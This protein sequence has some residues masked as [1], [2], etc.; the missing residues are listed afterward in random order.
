MDHEGGC[1]CGN[2]TLTLRL[3]KP[4]ADNPTRSCACSFCRGHATRTTSD[5]RGQADIRARDRTAVE[6]YRF[7]SHT[8]DYLICKICGIYIGAICDTA[9]GTRMVTNVNCLADRA[10]FPAASSFPNHDH[11]TTAARIA[12]R[13]ANWTPA[14]LRGLG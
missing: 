12:R 14:V 6:R 3:T 9:A 13:T 5:P 1:H 2:L 10:E 4:P 8:A 7:S 11:E